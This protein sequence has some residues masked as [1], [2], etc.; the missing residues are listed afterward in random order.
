MDGD[1]YSGWPGGGGGLFHA[2]GVRVELR[3]ASGV[4]ASSYRQFASI[5]EDG[6]VPAVIDLNSSPW[7][8]S[9]AQITTA[10]GM[11]LYVYNSDG[12]DAFEPD[13]NLGIFA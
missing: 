9:L 3:N 10:F 6:G 12:A 11:N 2:Y 1:V 5:F 7:A 4:L 13:T 8:L